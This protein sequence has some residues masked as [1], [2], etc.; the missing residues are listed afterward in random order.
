MVKVDPD[1]TDFNVK[2]DLVSTPHLPCLDILHVPEFIL[3]NCSI[4]LFISQSEYGHLG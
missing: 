1:Q 2:S 4:L 3:L